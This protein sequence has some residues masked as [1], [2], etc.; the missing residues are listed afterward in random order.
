MRALGKPAPEAMRV[1]AKR[2]GLAA[3]N[4]AAIGDDLNL[5]ILMAARDGGSS[6]SEAHK[7]LL[8]E[9]PRSPAAH[10]AGDFFV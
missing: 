9:V 7:K 3:K 1:A 10:T 5:K 8:P 2:L 6:S 4:L